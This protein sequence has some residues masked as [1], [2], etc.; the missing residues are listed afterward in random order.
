MSKRLNLSTVIALVM[1][2]VLLLFPFYVKADGVNPVLE[3]SSADGLTDL[4]TTVNTLSQDYGTFDFITIGT[5][6]SGNS[7]ITLD[8]SS[9]NSDSITSEQRKNLMEAALKSVNDSDNI[10]GQSKSRIYNFIA[11]QDEAT[12]SLVRQLSNDVNSDFASAYSYFKPFTS[13]LSTFFGLFSIGL[14]IALTLMILID[15]SFLVI[16]V[17]SSF[18]VHD[19]GKKPKIIS[20]E[21]WIAFKESERDA[22]NPKD[23]MAIYLK[24]KSIQLVCISICILYLVSG[25]IYVLVGNLIDMFKGF[26]S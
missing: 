1:G 5:V 15:I 19:D 13:T 25:K 2:I 3:V 9:Y 21:A 4:S 24:R 18:L 7:T 22:A 17:I 20:N 26:I 12:A 6:A 11:S 8:M 10:S 23:S 14:I 16:P